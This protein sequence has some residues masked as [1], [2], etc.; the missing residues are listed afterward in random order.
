LIVFELV[1]YPDFSKGET[2]KHY[3]SIHSELIYLIKLQ[4]GK[5]PTLQKQINVCNENQEEAREVAETMIV[6]LK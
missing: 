6:K 1:L 5:W 3:Q 4:T 2:R